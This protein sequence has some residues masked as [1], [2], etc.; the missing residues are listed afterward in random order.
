MPTVDIGDIPLR[1]RALQVETTLRDGERA[2]DPPV[3]SAAAVAVVENPYADTWQDDLALLTDWGAT[4]GDTLT[5]AAVDAVGGPDRV[6]SYGKGGIV[7]ERGELEHVA[8]MLHPELGTPMRAAVGGGDAIIPSAKKRGGQGTTLDVPTH[9]K[10]E[11]YVRSHYSAVAVRVH[12]APRGDELLLTVVVTDGGR[13]HP[14]IGGLTKA[15]V[16]E[17]DDTDA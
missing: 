1:K 2:V 8:A 17:R 5:R 3:T 12:D 7:G 16:A 9:Y 4:L 13:F 6:E 14:R 11:A 10:D 15:E